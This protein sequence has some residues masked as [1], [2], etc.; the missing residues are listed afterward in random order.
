MACGTPVICT[1]V[2][3]MPEL[4]EHDRNGFVIDPD[5]PSAITPA[6]RALLSDDTLWERM[7]A[8]ALA[9]AGELSWRSIARNCIGIYEDPSLGSVHGD[10]FATRDST[11]MNGAGTAIHCVVM[12]RPEAGGVA[13]C[14]S[15]LRHGAPG[16]RVHRDRAHRWRPRVVACP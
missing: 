4:V 13:Y 14:R 3:G 8:A 1:D 15:I 10:R 6:V 5:D 16:A 12:I 9:R 2:G 7:S 11:G